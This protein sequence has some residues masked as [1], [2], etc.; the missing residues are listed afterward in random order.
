MPSLLLP[1]AH[2][3]IEGIGDLWNGALH[4]LR[5]PAQIM[6][7]LGLGLF[8]GQRRRL[9]ANVG[10]FLLAA[11]VGLALTQWR[12]IPEPPASL[13]CLLSVLIGALVALRKPFPAGV[14]RFLFAASGFLL[15][16]DSQPEDVTFWSALK[17]LL[18]VWVGLAVLLLNFGNYAQ[19]APKKAWVKIGFRVLGSWILAVSI[20][21]LA[22][23]LKK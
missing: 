14:E 23:N 19:M 1:L 11:L 16:W 15:G 21:Y 9:R 20:L 22:F 12:A 7:L 6:V 4:P 8:L 5:S 13:L 3:S 18:G 2:G 10:A 17:V